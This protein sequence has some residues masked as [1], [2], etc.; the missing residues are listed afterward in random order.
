MPVGAAINLVIV[1]SQQTST[2][3]AEAVDDERDF[4]QRAGFRTKRVLRQRRVAL[5]ASPAQ[6]GRAI[7]RTRADSCSALVGAC[8]QQL[9]GEQRN[10]SA[11]QHLRR[12]TAHEITQTAYSWQHSATHQDDANNQAA[13]LEHKRQR[14]DT[15]SDRSRR[16]REDRTAQ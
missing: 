2:Y 7:S 13:V 4:N 14:Q 5:Q 8:N 15:S 10:R 16:Q 9:H 3:S 1:I 11:E 6:S 12:I